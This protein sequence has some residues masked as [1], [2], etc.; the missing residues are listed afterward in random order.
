MSAFLLTATSDLRGRSVDD[1][2]A[3]V[4]DLAREPDT[5]GAGQGCYPDSCVREHRWVCKTAT[6][7]LTIAQVLIG[8]VDSLMIE[9]R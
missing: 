6:D 1:Y 8:V 4:V 5:A 9:R 7:A 3:N 2:D